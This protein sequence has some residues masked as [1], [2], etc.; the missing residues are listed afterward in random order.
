M[1]YF[2]FSAVLGVYIV[3]RGLAEGQ[4]TREEWPACAL[5]VGLCTLLVGVPLYTVC[6]LG[7]GL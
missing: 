2:G 1:I 4:V 6:R 5:A 7:F 3:Y